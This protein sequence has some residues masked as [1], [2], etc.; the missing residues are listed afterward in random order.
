MIEVRGDSLLSL[1]WVRLLLSPAEHGAC[2]KP[3]E[4]GGNVNRCHSSRDSCEM[5]PSQLLFV[6]APL[7]AL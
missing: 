6:A 7:F 1:C 3:G 2:G 5:N 4:A